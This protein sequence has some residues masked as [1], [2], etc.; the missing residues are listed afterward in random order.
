MFNMPQQ[1]TNPK[2]GRGFPSTGTTKARRI[3][4]SG[5]VQLQ[6]SSYDYS[7]RVEERKAIRKQAESILA[8]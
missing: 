5:K 8:K 4:K 3:V 6:V 2:Y 7:P 1:M